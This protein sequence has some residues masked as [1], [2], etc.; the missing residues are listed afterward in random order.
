MT[1]RATSRSECNYSAVPAYVV[2]V[3]H[4]Q[5]CNLASGDG[6]YGGTANRGVQEHQP[7]FAKEGSSCQVV[8]TRALLADRHDASAQNVQG[9]SVVVQQRWR[10]VAVLLLLLRH[11]V[12][13]L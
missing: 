13:P 9:I 1:A 6:G 10:L 12:V 5:H 7:S 11:V 3:I 4:L 8:Q 2:K